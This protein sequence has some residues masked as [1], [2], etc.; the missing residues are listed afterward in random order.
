MK[1]IITHHT[2]DD[3]KEKEDLAQ[4]HD[5]INENP[6]IDFTLFDSCE[7]ENRFCFQFGWKVEI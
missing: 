7:I 6:Q 5:I 4:V 2:I 1:P 3:E